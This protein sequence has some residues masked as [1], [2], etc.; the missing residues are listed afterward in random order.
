MANPTPEEID[1]AIPVDGTPSRSLTNAAL[2][3]MAEAIDASGSAPG[4]ITDSDPRL[5]DSRAPTGGAGG[6]LSG[7]YPNPGFAVDL[8]TQAELDSGLA[9]KIST[10]ARGAANGVASLDATGKVPLS[11]L[12]VSGLQFKGAWNPNTNTPALVDGTGTTGDFYKASQAGTYNTGNA[13]HTYAVGDWIIF[14]G[15]IWTRLGSADAVATVN[16]RL[17]DVVLTAGDVGALPDTYQPDWDDVQNK[18]TQSSDGVPIGTPLM[19]LASVLPYGYIWMDQYV[20]G[21]YPALDAL[22]PSGLPSVANRVFRHVGNLTGAVGST[23]EDAMQ[24]V[25]GYIDNVW[26]G[27]PASQG[28]AFT[29]NATSGTNARPATGTQSNTRFNF[30]NADSA[31]ARTANET[32]VKSVI[33]RAIIKAYN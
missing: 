16:G 22:F 28:G 2:K 29:R 24:Q 17:G 11:E 7:S 13:S 14:A 26:T 18:P 20:A 33:F 19:W 3:S 21:V 1:A 5:T 6:V 32:R 4:G 25:T 15:G 23:Q 31:G 10:T 8:A 12:N 27:G 9:G 30:N